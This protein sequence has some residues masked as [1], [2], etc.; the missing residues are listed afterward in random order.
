VTLRFLGEVPDAEVPELLAAFRAA[1]GPEAALA[2]GPGT[3]RL[4]RATLVVPVAGADELALAV[5]EQTAAF[6]EPAEDRAFTGHV[7]LG[8]W[9][10]KGRLPQRFAGVPITASWTADELALVRSHVG[11][12]P[13]RYETLATVPLA[14]AP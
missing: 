4:G 8:R 11:D 2:L 13:A 1:G 5:Q 6:G 3:E 14:P 10:G 7:T 12:G 9:R